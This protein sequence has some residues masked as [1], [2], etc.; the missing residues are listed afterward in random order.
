MLSTKLYAFITAITEVPFNH[1]PA[2]NLVV[3]RLYNSIKLITK[4]LRQ[5]D[6][7]NTDRTKMNSTMRAM[8]KRVT[9]PADFVP[10]FYNRN[11]IQ[12]VSSVAL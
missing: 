10:D 5:W 2:D 11:T 7:E 6:W 4:D 3:A 1:N 9:V 8:K 12:D